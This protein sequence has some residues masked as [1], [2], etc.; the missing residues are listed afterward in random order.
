MSDPQ[1]ET[2]QAT[3]P[4]S[5]PVA[6]WFPYCMMHVFLL[7]G[8][9][10]VVR[11]ATSYRAI[12]N[13]LDPVWIGLIGGTFGILPAFFGL[14]L[15]SLLDRA[16]ETK[17][18]RVG[19][20]LVLVATLLLW[21]FGAHLS[22][23]LGASLI[24]GFG[25]FICIAGQQSLITRCAPRGRRESLL[26]Y[27][28]TS[29]SLAQAVSPA[30]LAWFGRGSLVPDTNGI[31]L[32][33]VIASV[34]LVAVIFMLSAPAHQPEQTSLSAW[35]RAYILLRLRGYG[36]LS[37]AGLVIFSGMDLLVVYLPVFGAERQIPADQIGFLLIMRAMS[38]IVA[39]LFFAKLMALVPRGWLL[40]GAM[41]LTGL[42]ILLVT[43]TSNVYA[44]GVEMFLVG[45]G[46]GVAPVLIISWISDISPVG[47]RATALSVRL[48]INRFG[49]ALLPMSSGVL[50]AG[51]GAIG[52][53]WAIALSIFASAFLTGVHFRVWRKSDPA[54]DEKP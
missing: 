36:V 17:P 10:L 47:S 4:G 11:V 34:A 19:S 29:I 48:A 41:L 43:L 25:Q 9:I 52:V 42:G 21:E 51:A 20:I 27:F 14:H 13:N 45:L 53:L 40:V 3:D 22:V 12:E 23:L 7:Q 30:I 49:Q 37:F 5:V 26:G 50:V 33:G 16:G 1:S 32:S 2:P 39:R 8:M 38:S 54:G 15:G 44:M 35:S 46:F 18:M 6:S 28:T 24:L 31:F